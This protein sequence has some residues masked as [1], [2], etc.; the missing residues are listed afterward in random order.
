MLADFLAQITNL[1]ALRAGQVRGRGAFH[2]L[3]VAALDRTVTLP[4][5]IDVALV[6]AKDLHL[7]VTR[8]DDH[9]FQITFAVAKGGLGLA[10]AFAD[11]L[12]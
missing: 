11:L 2:D 7:D 3:L 6:V 10:A 9:L 4:Q 12:L 5:M 8:L 1:L